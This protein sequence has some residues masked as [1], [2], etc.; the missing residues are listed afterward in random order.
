MLN[1]LVKST[2]AAIA[3]GDAGGQHP[4]AA[5]AQATATPSAAPIVAPVVV[6][7]EPVA[8]HVGSLETA[9]ATVAQPGNSP[10]ELEAFLINFV[11]E[12]TGYPAEVVDLDADLEA[13]LGIDSIKKAQ[14]FGELQ[15][16]FDISAL[17]A[18]GA[19]GG[20]LSLDDFSTLRHVLNF[21]VTSAPAAGG[22]AASNGHAAAD[23]A[24]PLAAAQINTV[25]AATAIAEPPPQPITLEAAPVAT[26]EPAAGAPGTS[27]AELEAFLINFVV[28]QTGYPAEVVDL[29]ADLEA[30]LGIDSIKKAQLFGE[31]QEYFD[32]SALG[33]GGA[34]S[35][36]LSLDDFTT[37][38]HVLDFLVQ[39]RSGAA[40]KA[41]IEQVLATTDP[42]P[43]VATSI[44]QPAPATAATDSSV[45][46]DTATANGTAE[47]ATEL[48]A[49]LI[50][51]VVEQT[52]YPAEVVDLD[53][54]LEADLGIDSIKKAQLF[55]ELQEYFDISA[56]GAGGAGGGTL[57]LDDFTTLRHVLNFLLGATPTLPESGDAAVI[58]EP[59]VTE[60]SA[61]DHEMPD[62]IAEVAPTAYSE[63]TEAILPDSAPSGCAAVEL[64]GTPYDIGWQHGRRFKTE[65][66]R[67]LRHYADCVGDQLDELPGQTA[68]IAPERALSADELDELQGLADAVEVPLG[69][70]LAHQLALTS[71]LGAGAGQMA[72]RAAVAGSTGQWIHALR[73]PAPLVGT[74]RA[75]AQPVVFVRCPTGEIAHFA[76]SYLGCVGILGGLNAAGVSIT[77]HRL[78]GHSSPAMVLGAGES[79]SS[80]GGVAASTVV[81]TILGSA[82]TLEQ[83]IELARSLAVAGGQAWVA[84]ITSADA[85][86]AAAI[87]FD[88]RELR[89]QSAPQMLAVGQLV[90]G[91]EITVP[92]DAAALATHLASGSPLGPGTAAMSRTL[93]PA[94]GSDCVALVIKP[95]E[96]KLWVSG[97]A[98]TDG[99]SVECWSASESLP[100]WDGNAAP[101]AAVGRAGTESPPF[102]LPEKPIT[103][104]FSLEMRE[105]P[106]P[107]GTAA[108]PTWTG[109][110]II[111]GTGPTAEALRHRLE[112]SGVAV[113]MLEP[114]GDADAVV[115]EVEAICGRG[116]AP[117]LFLTT[118]RDCGPID[119][120]HIELWNEEHYTTMML[121]FLVCQKWTQLAAAGGWL[122]HATV[123]AT[124]AQGGDFGFA[125]GS[126]VAQGGSLAGLLKAIFVE[127]AI[128]QNL[129][130]LRIKVIDA[131]ADAPADTLADQVLAELASGNLAYE[132]A[133]VGS[134]RLVSYAVERNIGPTATTPTTRPGSA[135][136]HGSTWVVTGGARGITAAAAMELGRRFGLKLHLLG[137]TPLVAID[138]AWRELTAEGLQKLKASVMI[139]A[140][141]AG[142]P[143]AQA[144]QRVEKD[145]EIDRTLRGFAAAGVTVTY[146][147][148]DVSDRA[149]MAET[150]D[151]IREADGPIAGILHGAGVERSCRFER[152]QRDVVLLTIRAKVDGTANLMA[153]TRRDPIRHFIVFG[154]ISGRVGG[155]GQADYSLA[156]EMACKLLGSY[157]RARPWVQAVGFHWHAWDEVGMAARP[158]TKNNL[159]EKGALALM[160]LAEGLAHLVREMAAGTPEPEVMITERHHWERFA[161]GLGTLAAEVRP[162]AP[163]AEQP[164]TELPLL[165]N[166]VSDGEGTAGQASLDPTADQF[167]IQHRLR[168][169]PLLPVVVGLEA[170][171]EAASAA[172]GRPISGFRD[173]DMIDGLLFHVER[174]AV[175]RARATQLPDGTLDC[176]LTSDFYNRNGG[177]IQADRLYL[178]TKAVPAG[179]PA[180]PLTKILPN[181]GEWRDFS[182]P[183]E[184]P[185]YHG[186][187]FRGLR[188][189]CYAPGKG[190]ARLLALPL[191]DLV[192]PARV[193]GWTI[194]S[195]LLDSAMYACAMHLWAF[196]ENAIA[197][198]RRIADLRLIRQPND[199]EKCLIHFVCV[200]LPSGLYD[201]D[202]VGEDG[203][204]IMQARGYGHVI[205]ARGVSH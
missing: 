172:A 8:T 143:T 154:S 104:R 39:S 65:I 131:P 99:K 16:Y 89:V 152:K 38:R 133:Y 148:C 98:T 111:L 33:A 45:A 92:T 14:L 190:T 76:V 52:G 28:E 13:D 56:L 166:L 159:Q 22:H 17:G 69:N 183:N 97:S 11:V 85:A 49:F 106:L 91:S 171:T 24:A 122:E 196:G 57:S 146:H 193:T 110:A 103:S 3:S 43:A 48:E 138:P 135:I 51:F 129:K 78:D 19:G 101:L 70:M 25:Q 165:S 168:G 58:D 62:P 100:A 158:E 179:V 120:Y 87:E 61:A 105:A 121:P 194:P 161:A 79:F 178:A 68:G 42:A 155:F 203:T 117:H 118:A 4:A 191:V 40:A 188:G 31:L 86:E 7:A 9:S 63:P 80:T 142:K 64:A 32:I 150:L 180:A 44:T 114:T 93:A 195:C 137:T 163:A 170:L 37:L 20:S 72:W 46:N 2:S 12:Q 182:Y 176:R 157:R 140:R 75:V 177:L 50:N 18:G 71:E 67:I 5:V 27:P 184:A 123:V 187:V 181:I 205:F 189:C 200:D 29:D 112:R 197:L 139:A 186:P 204:V 109:Q 167:L 113:H 198:P 124:T 6:L 147:A 36:T 173:I 128:M 23:V 82:T 41:S 119:P 162:S 15:E 88:G 116:P 54:D 151:R 127:Y 96:A 202:V 77:A 95:A 35:G 21:L 94:V 10:A 84:L 149:A 199:G 141:N 66:Q 160:P 74:L 26:A 153:L 134:R 1:F 83:A 108:K 126:E 34:G 164:M 145:L 47:R 185:I 125:R 90:A 55:G 192:G 130:N 53:A 107:P 136:R 174:P 73:Q 102:G 169:K 132:V 59:V 156:N 60:E 201:F 30:D 115:A 175:V 144:W 81:R